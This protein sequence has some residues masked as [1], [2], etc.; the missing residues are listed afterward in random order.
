M[1]RERWAGQG[2]IL[3]GKDFGKPSRS[4]TVTPDCHQ[5]PC[6]RTDLVVEKAIPLNNQVA[7][8]LAAEKMQGLDPTHGGPDIGMSRIAGH[9]NKVML[10]DK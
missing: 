1:G 3:A 4:L 8:R 10:A 5:A 6:H 2:T 9:G 7:T